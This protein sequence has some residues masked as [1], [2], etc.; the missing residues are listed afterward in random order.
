MTET[1][2]PR[3]VYHTALAIVPPSQFHEAVN[4]IRSKHDKAYPRWMPHINVLFPFIEVDDTADPT[5]MTDVEQQLSAALAS[6]P[7]FD[8]TLET[9]NHFSRKG[10]NLYFL[11]P[12]EKCRPQ[13]DV[14]VRVVDSC[15]SHSLGSRQ[16]RPFK[17]HMTVGQWP[18]STSASVMKATLE[19]HWT[20]LTWHCSEISVLSR[21]D[22]DRMKV[23]KTIKLGTHTTTRKASED[24]H[25]SKSSLLANSSKERRRKLRTQHSDGRRG[26]EG[27]KTS[28]V[29]GSVAKQNGAQPKSKRSDVALVAPKPVVDIGINIRDSQMKKTW[30]DQLRRA[31]EANVSSVLLTGTSVKCSR[32]SIDLAR[33]WNSVS[34]VR[35]PKLYCTAGVHPHDANSWDDK[36]LDTLRSLVTETNHVVAVGECGLD[37]NRN[38][39]TKSQQLI[40]FE[41][42][43]SLAIELQLPVFVHE[44]EAHE[45]LLMVLDKFSSDKIPPVVVHCFTGTA[46][47]AQEYIRRG[48][49]IGFTGT[50][51]KEQRGRQLRELLPELPLSRIMLETDAPW[52]GFV[53]GR[54]TSEPMDVTRVAHR[55]AEVLQKPFEEVCEA[56][57]NNAHIFFGLEDKEIAP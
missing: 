16:K 20:P 11:R 53:K 49:Y 52:M 13:I 3:A 29:V 39:S 44:R 46:P 28:T 41:A 10:D 45:D 24:E 47:E 33:Q 51:C 19:Q 4:E 50:I 12:S 17:P 31:G 21:R 32:E 18:K 7:A 54:R 9:F 55:L 6:V 35:M 57:T 30:K 27:T 48:F 5:M 26:D 42:Q 8:I 56:T 38:F 36:T 34:T 22:D 23:R 25:S 37:Y 2:E 43:V 15:L 1:L 40:A 14:L